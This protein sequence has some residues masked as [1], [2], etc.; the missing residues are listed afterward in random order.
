RSDTPMDCTPIFEPDF[1]MKAWLNA[2]F[3]A[4]AADEPEGLDD[5]DTANRLLAKLQSYQQEVG[6]LLEES[7]TSAIAAVPRAAREM[8]SVKQEALLLQDQLRSVKSQLERVEQ[9]TS[10]SMA[11]LVEADR[12]KSRLQRASSALREADNWTSLSAN[13]DDLLDSDD[14]AGIADRLAQLA[15][16]LS[17]LDSSPDYASRQQ[18]LESWRNQFEAQLAVHVYRAFAGRDTGECARLVGLLARIGRPAAA[19]THYQ[20][21]LTGHL[22]DVWSA[23]AASAA[24]S[25]KQDDSQQAAEV[26]EDSKTA[27]SEDDTDSKAAKAV[28]TAESS[29]DALLSACRRELQASLLSD[30]RRLV[31]DCLARA[32][33]A[34][35]PSIPDVVRPKS[36]VADAAQPD[37]HVSLRRLSIMCRSAADLADLFPAAAAH[38][39]TSSAMEE[40][41]T[42]ALSGLLRPACP[43]LLADIEQAAA[44][45]LS[46]DLGAIPMDQSDVDDTL[47][48][49]ENATP[50]AMSSASR[51]SSA[52]LTV[53]PPVCS[54]RL[55]R[56]LPAHLAN[57]LREL[58]RV[59]GNVR[60]KLPDPS[61]DWSAVGVILRTGCLLGRLVDAAAQFAVEFSDSCLTAAASSDQL[62]LPDWTVLVYADSA[63]DDRR[64]LRELI[65]AL[66]DGRQPGWLREMRASCQAFCREQ[67]RLLFG[68]L[69]KPVDRLLSALPGLPCWSP[70]PD[71]PAAAQQL[72]AFGYLASECVAQVGQYL[73]H[74]PQQLGPFLSA[75]T[76]GLRSAIAHSGLTQMLQHHHHQQHQR[77]GQQQQQAAETED[78]AATATSDQA[79]AGIELWIECVAAHTMDK[80]VDRA[81]EIPQLT[82][83][84]AVQQLI[85]D[86]NYLA[87]CLDDLGVSASDRL[88]ALRD[89]VSAADSTAFHRRAAEGAPR[90][91]VSA[92][93]RMR[94]FGAA[95]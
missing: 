58:S 29:L 36:T 72:P 90:R 6:A 68:L 76:P 56:L 59:L 5:A 16:S 48:L 79:S 80:F 1:D 37:L 64:L 74:L 21:W 26:A 28:E 52:C 57:Y 93:A 14:L 4:G 82:A 83:N 60:A 32:L 53:S 92:V 61:D 42:A 95:N 46:S 84:S 17:M 51:L 88:Q 73:L 31:L 65:S 3:A 94:D 43:N 20:R 34:L 38:D 91:I 67:H 86:A 30:C 87:S 70:R 22:A 71:D 44:Q 19:N 24:G 40:S 10:A 62:R 2:A 85:T 39:G 63:E 78:G 8:A 50:L 81:M 15:Q 69:A 12:L 18:Q 41:R 77:L 33:P 54:A 47:G 23:A 89:L 49:L 35:R 45:Q 75:D 27:A 7:W 11:K 9:E 25:A 66:Q 13:L 55:A